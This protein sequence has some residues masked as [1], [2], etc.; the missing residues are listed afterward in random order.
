MQDFIVK[1]QDRTIHIL[2]AVSPGWT[3]ALPF[4]R[5]IVDNYVLGEKAE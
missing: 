2:N 5:W 1:N 3:S 4:G